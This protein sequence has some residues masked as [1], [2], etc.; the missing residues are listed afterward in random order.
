MVAP[1][2][3]PYSKNI[4]GQFSS[5][6]SSGMKQKRPYTEPLPYSSVFTE[7]RDRLTSSSLSGQYD[8][9]DVKNLSWSP[10]GNMSD[11]GRHRQHCYNSAYERLRSEMSDG[12]AGWAENMAQ[13]RKSADMISDRLVQ[14]WRATNAI[15]RG[16]FGVAASALRLPKPE[17]VSHQK[18]FSKNFLEY[19]YGWAP[20]MGDIK[21]GMQILTSDPGSRRFRGK[22]KE[23]WSDHEYL[24]GSDSL[25]SWSTRSFQRTTLT[26]TCRAKV[27][28]TNPN[29]FLADSLGLIDPALPWKLLPFSFV[30]DWFVNVEQI[31]SAMTGWLGV[32]LKH[33]HYT[34]FADGFYRFDGNTKFL[35]FWNGVAYE[36][37]TISTSRIKCVQVNRVMGL[38]SP[39]LVVKPFSGFSLQRGLQAIALII[40]T[41]GR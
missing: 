14:I 39:A 11:W 38:P 23:S 34:E 26:I 2:T 22:R 9:G 24:Y 16:N 1:V 40:A 31:L 28:I 3:G 18:A 10:S 27:R 25:G 35:E 32:E 21:A 8:S 30:V 15:R 6:V 33:P 17:K 13:F 29:L 7:G 36:G 41:L 37:T 20:L 19:E 5:K 4:P 12:R